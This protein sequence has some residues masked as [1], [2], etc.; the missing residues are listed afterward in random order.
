MKYKLTLTNFI[1]SLMG[2]LSL[3]FTFVKVFLDKYDYNLTAYI[4][5]AVFVC[6]V[7]SL[8]NVYIKRAW[9]VN[10]VLLVM[11][12]IYL[13]FFR[14]EIIGGYMAFYN[15]IAD[16]YA[17]E[18]D[19]PMYFAVPT[20]KWFTDA[21]VQLMTGYSVTVIGIVYSL[22]ISKMTLVFIPLFINIVFPVVPLIININPPIVCILLDFVFIID[23]FVMT[24]ISKNGSK[25]RKAVSNVQMVS[26][27][28]GTIV[29]VICL[30]ASLIIPQ[31]GYVKSSYF[32]KVGDFAVDVYGRIENK[33]ISIV[34]KKDG[35][36]SLLNGNGN[37]VIENEK[38]GQVDEINYNHTEMIQVDVCKSSDRI[39]IKQFIG[40]EYLNNS[41]KEIEKKD[42]VNLDS[43]FFEH[44]TS[45]QEIT[46]E[47][48]N[49]RLS[50]SDEEDCK[51]RMG[52]NYTGMKK[53][54][55]LMPVY[56][57][58]ETAEYFDYESYY[59]PIGE[60]VY[61]E[62]FDLNMDSIQKMI[63]SDNELLKKYT[64]Y[65]YDTY[66]QTDG[67]CDEQ[68]KKLLNNFKTDTF[69]DV[70]LLAEYIR[71]HLAKRCS[72]TLQPGRIPAGKDFVDYFYNTSKKGYCTYFATTAV[73][74][75]RSKGV[76]ARY[77]TGFAFE[78]DENVIDEFYIFGNEM[79]RISVDDSSAH[80]WI[81]LFIDG[82]GWVQF[83][84]TPGNFEIREIEVPAMEPTS[85]AEE[86]TAE[87][88]SSSDK[89]TDTTT[90]HDR[91]TSV[92]TKDG[93]SENLKGISKTVIKNIVC[94]A[95]II[96]I[97][98]IIISIILI[99]YRILR[100]GY[101]LDYEECR[102]NNKKKCIKYNYERMNK[103][104]TIAGFNRNMDM[105][106]K[107]YAQF[108]ADECQYAEN[109]PIQKITDLFEKAEF[110]DNEITDE[111]ITQSE[112]IVD[113]ICNRVY[114]DIGFAK[115]IK[116]KYLYY[117]I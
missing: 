109:E 28:I 85:P 25:D 8:I 94:V 107:V 65:V 80:A 23:M 92:Q 67:K 78:P 39:Y 51:K 55:Q 79:N 13:W 17:L 88:E 63:D 75:L 37:T 117:L 97:V 48:I 47:I 29:M 46:S 27:A 98:L 73:M 91:P 30:V 76:P 105:T 31:K 93:K 108:L 110:S 113:E 36:N 68:F 3:F 33:I 1:I 34:G 111:D 22:L 102:K 12:L 43:Y 45:V 101:R 74:M 35:G 24:G 26:L 61:F 32:N 66:L 106:Y 71:Q 2:V 104:L 20:G 6:G 44:N 86:T 60:D 72:Y 52:I 99:R 64:D 69:S 96:F 115:K 89:G 56:S 112:Y 10:V 38:L 70:M 21:N 57:F 81:E 77:V 41:W 62:Y 50:H 114:T 83:D 9:I 5:V 82:F 18:F 42:S 87:K 116:F 7:M 15:V 14:Y 58:T 53:A 19:M 90:R 59:H 16:A 40:K 95:V 4:L 11:A 100:T 54:R 103:A 84:V 49:S